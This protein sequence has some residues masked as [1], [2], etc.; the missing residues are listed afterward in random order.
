M[1]RTPLYIVSSRPF[2]DTAAWHQ[3]GGSVSDLDGGVLRGSLYVDG[4]LE[5]TDTGV[6]NDRSQRHNVHMGNT[7]A[8][9]RALSGK[10]DD[11]R[12]YDAALSCG[13]LQSLALIGVLQND[14]DT[15]LKGLSAVLVSTGTGS[16][17]AT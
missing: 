12:F 6:Q 10:I 9:T 2:A 15:N 16:G 13:R 17:S 8:N 7:G 5:G 1:V 11:G 3:V 4:V 14:L